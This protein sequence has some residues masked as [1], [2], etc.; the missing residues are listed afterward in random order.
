[1]VQKEIVSWE[2]V[3]QYIDTLAEKLSPWKVTGVYGIPRGGCVLAVMLSYK[4]NI[5]LLVAPCENCVVIDDIA[6]TG[7][8]LLHYN[9]NKSY[10]ITTMYF[11]NQS[12]IEPDFWY[13]E[14]RDKWVVYPW[15]EE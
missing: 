9:E 14:K 8:T 5:P 1:M 11:H 3:Q 13:L 10:Y 6:D 12:L 7:R 15:E 2:M 4:L